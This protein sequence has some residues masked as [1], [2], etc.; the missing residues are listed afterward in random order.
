MGRDFQRLTPAERKIADVIAARLLLPVTDIAAA[1]VNT[2]RCVDVEG[3]TGVYI[4]IC[5]MYRELL[6][7]DSES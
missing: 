1:I 4:D 5:Q 7:G 6:G 3:L 2:N